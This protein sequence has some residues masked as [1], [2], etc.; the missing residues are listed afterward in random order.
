MDLTTEYLGLK[1]KSPLVPSASPLTRDVDSVRRLEDA[2]ASA[3]VL[4]SLFEEQLAL[5]S[6]QLDHFLSYF[7]DA[8][9]E[10]LTFFPQPKDFV[11]GSEQYLNL[12]RKAKAA[13]GIP[14]IASLNGVT[15]GGWIAYAKKMEQAGADALELN[16][17]Y[18]ATDPNTDSATVE[19]M[20]VNVLSAVRKAVKVPVAVKLS[21]YFSAT[22]NMARRLAMA[23]ANGLVL[24]NR[25]YQPDLDLD[26]LEVKPAVHLSSSEELRLPLRW[27]AILY[28]R[29]PAD[30]ALSSGVHTHEDVLKGL[31][32]GAKVTMM[33]S[34]LLAKGPRRIKEI[35]AGMMKWMEER[36]YASVAQMQGSMSQRNVSSPA[37]FERANYMRVLQSWRPDPTG[38][39]P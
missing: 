2:G 8:V 28:G 6:Q 33:A 11:L 5:E 32:A 34:E 29:V 37:A 14:V 35:E 18:I 13:V 26:S 1:L 17:Y 3:V 9:A 10:S 22:A 16:V 27:I 23:G 36:G 30:F 12:I 20:T 19:N 39:M 25:F 38:K 21:P 7:T 24:F 15:T 4:H 31:M